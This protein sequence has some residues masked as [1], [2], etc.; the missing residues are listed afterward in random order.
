MTDK[1][2]PGPWRISPQRALT[3]RILAYGIM[4][5]NDGDD[6]DIAD[7]NVFEDYEP[8]GEANAALIAAA[9]E[10]VEALRG[11]VAAALPALLIYQE[12]ARPSAE[13]IGL[14]E[15]VATARALLD[16]IEKEAN[17]GA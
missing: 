8:E 3:G 1:W 15:S 12:D 5:K 10:L 11:L 6:V 7:V 9:P 14:D 4:G 17:G 13:H 2:T 16:R